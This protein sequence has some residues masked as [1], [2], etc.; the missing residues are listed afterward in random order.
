MADNQE[1]L[2]VI[3]E[4]LAGVRAEDPAGLASVVEEQGPEDVSVTSLEAVAV[5]VELQPQ[6]GIDPGDRGILE[7][8]G[9]VR[10]LADLFR[11]VGAG[12]T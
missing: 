10:T 4:A 2:R 9:R 3:L 11:I 5:L 12:T 6:T 7:G 1:T 8:C